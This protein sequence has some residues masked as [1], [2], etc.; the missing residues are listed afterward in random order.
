MS[1]ILTM[2]AIVTLLAT[3]FVS[4]AMTL[5]DVSFQLSL[6]KKEGKVLGA[7]TDGS[8]TSYN[9]NSLPTES[10]K[11]LF[12][13]LK[14]VSKGSK[15]VITK[16]MRFGTKDCVDVKKLQIFLNATGDLDV[17]PTCYF[18]PKTKE[19]LKKFQLRKGIN[20]DGS[21]FGPMTRKAMS[22]QIEGAVKE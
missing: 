17:E 11:T 10:S 14:Y 18:G 4:S 9:N 15:D 13:G 7:T 21:A 19:A 16:N 12:K 22:E 1:K 20:S 6:F 2:F 3:P 5:E 8:N